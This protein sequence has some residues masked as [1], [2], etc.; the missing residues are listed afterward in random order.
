M[1]ALTSGVFAPGRQIE[2]CNLAIAFHLLSAQ[3][4]SKGEVL[5]KD[6]RASLKKVLDC[7]RDKSYVHR[8]LRNILAIEDNTVRV[9]D[10]V[11]YPL[12]LNLSS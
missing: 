10:T 3:A 5:P 2:C 8:D 12:D 11:I 4:R 1:H 7:P 9:L 6:L